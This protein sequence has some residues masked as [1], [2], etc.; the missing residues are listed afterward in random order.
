MHSQWQRMH[1]MHKVC[2][3]AFCGKCNLFP[4]LREGGTYC[5]NEDLLFMAFRGK[6]HLLLLINIFST[7]KQ[8]GT[9]KILLDS[10]V[11][12]LL[13][14]TLKDKETLLGITPLSKEP[15]KHNPWVGGEM[16]PS[17]P[18]GLHLFSRELSCAYYFKLIIS[19][20]TFIS[21]AQSL[22]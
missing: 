19:L 13:F 15:W 17:V 9:D 11:S 20:I 1:N 8:H 3:N 12:E 22:S 18:E 21:N 4:F 5:G 6:K 7:W 10:P 14:I 16:C 2:D